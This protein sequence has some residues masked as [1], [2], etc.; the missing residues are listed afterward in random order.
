MEIEMKMAVEMEVEM[1]KEGGI[2]RE[3]ARRYSIPDRPLAKQELGGRK[4]KFCAS[5]VTSCCVLPW[6]H[7]SPR[8]ML[9]LCQSLAPCRSALF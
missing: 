7:L 9:L 4:V 6:S 8:E 2:D 1:G 3:K 5:L